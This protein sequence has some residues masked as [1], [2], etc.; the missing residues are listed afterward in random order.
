MSDATVMAGNYQFQ[1]DMTRQMMIEAMSEI[2]PVVS[3]REITH[4]Q[5]RVAMAER[6]SKK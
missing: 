2:Q 3:V 6:I 1:M 5:N 4:A